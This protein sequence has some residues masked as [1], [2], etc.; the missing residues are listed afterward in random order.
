MQV[1]AVGRLSDPAQFGDIII[2][3]NPATGSA[4]RLRDAARIE[5]GALQYSSTAFFGEEPTVVL[6]IFQM[7]GSNALD[8]QNNIKAKMEELSKR[9]PK[10]ISYAMH[11]DTTRFVSA[12]MHD[13][14]VTLLEALALVVAVVFIFLQSWRTTIIPTIAIPVSL[15]AT[16]VVMK[17]FGFSLNMLSLLG[18]V[19]A[20]G[21]VVDDAIV[22]VENVERQ[23]EAGLAAARSGAGGDARGHRSDHRDDRRADGGVRA[24]GVHPRRRR[25]PLQPVRADRRDLGRDLGLQFAHAQPGAQRRIPAPP[26]RDEVSPVPLVQSRLRAARRLLCR[27]RSHP[28]AGAMGHHGIVRASLAATFF[29]SQRV[30]STFLPVE[31]QGYFFVVIQLPDGASLERTD[32]VAKQVREILQRT[33]GVDIVGSI[34]GLNFLTNAAQSNSAVEFA[35]LKPWDERPPE[36]TASNI[37]ASVRPKLLGLPGGLRAELRPAVDPGTRRHGRFR[38]PG[39]GS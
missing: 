6:G 26:R 18:M 12:A 22:V 21:L 8:L 13:V 9:F 24:G 33:P 39:R 15:V 23:L 36:Q 37:V 38:V 34:S 5:L 30:P 7:P 3:A 27:Q 32:A 10:G 2:R 19:L 14:V 4:V 16:L 25:P 1:N 17:M 35:I 31:D 20:I 11:Y 28:G 29:L